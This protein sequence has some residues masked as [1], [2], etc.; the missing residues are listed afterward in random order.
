[1]SAADGRAAAALPPGRAGNGATR[2]GAPTVRDVAAAAGVTPMT[3]SRVLRGTSGFSAS[4]RERVMRA[5]EVLGYTPNA[6]AQGL[7]THQTRTVALL[8]GNVASP[9]YARMARGFEAAMRAAGYLTM[10]CNTDQSRDEEARYL[11]ELLKRRVDGLAVAPVESQS[12]LLRSF[13]ARGVPLVLV[14]REVPGLGVDTVTADGRAGAA[15]ATR[16]LIRVHGHRRVAALFGPGETSTGRARRAGY[17]AALGEAGLN[18]ERPLVGHCAYTVAAARDLSRR[19]LTT[20]PRPTALL[21]AGN[22]LTAGAL[23]AMAELRLSA[24]DD[25]AL[26][27]VGPAPRSALERPDLTMVGLPSEAMGGRAAGLL[28]RRLDESGPKSPAGTR[29]GEPVRESFPA[30]LQLRRSCGCAGPAGD[31]LP[32]AG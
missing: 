10:I 25:V 14:D 19:I 17:E 12:P 5:V 21:A 26:I 4:T 16:H 8:I 30:V 3:V 9:F 6:V 1:V 2:S 11:A 29:E 22:F 13:L 23:E 24:P 15:G 20:S 7:R 31:E 28:L 27:G 18:V 32:A